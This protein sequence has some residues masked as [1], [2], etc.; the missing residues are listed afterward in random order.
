MAEDTAAVTSQ[1]TSVANDTSEESD[2]TAPENPTAALPDPPVPA[3]PGPRA[4]W[5]LPS[6]IG[7]GVLLLVGALVA[8]FS[9]W[10]VSTAA[11]AR[12]EAASRLDQACSQLEQR[13]NRLVPPG[14][15]SSAAD[16]AEAIRDEDAAVRILT[17]EL[18]RLPKRARNYRSLP[19]DWQALITARER[20]AIDLDSGPRT[21]RP[22]FFVMVRTNDGTD[23]V[24]RI[25]RRSPDSCD[26]SVR[27]LA[28]PDL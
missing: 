26:A 5:L 18:D 24:D 14:A 23:R 27:R 25:I 7:L 16:R 9:V 28:T 10:R 12:S 2:T 4:R 1:P 22:A 13:L 11:A 17:A 8:G 3:D 15:T 6:A 20:Y 21:G 19:G